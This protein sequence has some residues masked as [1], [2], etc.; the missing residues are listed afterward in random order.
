MLA[1]QNGPQESNILDIKEPDPDLD[2]DLKL[3]RTQGGEH[4]EAKPSQSSV[5]GNTW[6]AHS[7]GSNPKPRQRGGVGG[8]DGGC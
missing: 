1:P 5:P 6:V 4:K 8:V 7:R 2:L 3:D